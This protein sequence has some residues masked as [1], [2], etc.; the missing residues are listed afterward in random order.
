MAPV[1]LLALL[2]GACEREQ[3][4]YHGH[5]QDGTAGGTALASP[6]PGGRGP[7]SDPRGVHAANDAWDIGQGQLYYHWFNCSGCH[8]NG[9]GGI[10][11]ALMDDAWRYGGSIDQ[12]HSSIMQGR[13]NGMPSF[14]G[15]IPAQQAWQVAAYIRALSG[16]VRMDA[17]PSRRDGM[18]ATPP[19][20]RLPAQ[21]PRF[22]DPASNEEPQQ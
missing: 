2:A 1:L 17:L 10:G 13:P 22:G 8:G 9:G 19:L 11:P 20:T 3:R 14:R 15:R 16:N 5:A 12:I 21:P 7:V 18:L 4:D 6:M